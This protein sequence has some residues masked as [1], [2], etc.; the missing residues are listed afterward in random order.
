M[1]NYNCQNC[2]DK[3]T[4]IH[5]GKATDFSKNYR[6]IKEGEILICNRCLKECKERKTDLKKIINSRDKDKKIILN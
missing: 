5:P 4:L 2:G 3:T 6:N 1:L